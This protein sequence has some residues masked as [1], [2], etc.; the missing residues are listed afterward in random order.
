[1]S[2][3]AYELLF[4]PGTSPAEAD[5]PPPTFVSSVDAG[6]RIERN[7]AIKL[8]DGA[9][10]YIDVYR[11]DGAVDVPA[12]VAW[13][14]YG[15]HNGGAVYQQFRD[16]NGRRGG[17]VR[18]EWLSPYTTFEGPDPRR[19]CDNGY[20]VVNVDPRGTWWSDGP[21]ATFWDEREAHDAVEV[22]DWVGTRPWGNG[23]V[24]LSGVS[25][26]AVAQWWI[27]SLRPPHLAAINPCEGLSD[28]Y[29]EFAF[30]GGIPS[31]FP[32][33]WQQVR[34]KYSTTKVEAMA[35]MM[36]RHPFDDAYWESKRPD[37]S[38]IDVPAYVLASWSDQGLHTRGTLRAFEQLSSA[39]KY[40][41]VHGR[42]KW[43]Y[44]HQ[45]STLE[46]QRLFFDRYLKGV[47]NEVE[48]WPQVRLE[49]RHR[50]YYGSQLTPPAWPLTDNTLRRLHL[51]ASGRLLDRRPDSA[52]SVRYAT[53]PDA[54]EPDSEGAT[55]TEVVFDHR[56]DAPTDVIGGMRLRLWVEAEGSDDLDLFVAVLKVDSHGRLV[57]FPFANVLER[58]PVALGWLRASSRALD[59]Q[60]STDDRPWHR[61]HGE[62][63]LRPGE[64]VPVDVE[65]WPSSTRFDAGETLRVALRGSDFYAGAVMSRHS[66][67]RSAGVHV[68][69]TGGEHDSFLVLPT[70]PADPSPVPYAG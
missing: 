44:Y 61:H 22:I 13:G 64:I 3:P 20:A 32:T 58:G 63:R 35:D 12:L 47:D 15:K 69:H 16:E 5:V 19:W 25:Y 29:R 17:G 66:D 39:P 6:M 43:E 34:L 18:P 49:V 4:Q 28:V 68:V 65:V 8:A 70:R 23:K 10:L 50:S 31:D 53:G 48:D 21:Y 36:K 7:A 38:Q 2:G 62:Q 45:P 37:L 42:K 9:L 26:L 67:T 54:V 14:P 51:D 59:E 1:M 11:P 57:D 60:R 33:F 24:G 52:A 46:R 41:E 56:F 55:P 30:H 27:A 40:L